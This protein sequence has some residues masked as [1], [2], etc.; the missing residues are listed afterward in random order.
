[1]SPPERAALLRVLAGAVMISFSA[2]LAKASGA[3][4]TTISFYRMAIGGLFL[5]GIALVRRERFRPWRAAHGWIL[6]AAVFIYLDL[7]A[8]HRS[9]LYVG[10]GLATILGNFQ[11]FFLALFGVFVFKEPLTPRLLGAMPLAMLGIWLLAGVDPASRGPHTLLGVAFGIGTALFYSAYLLLLRH[12]QRLH[13]RLPVAA[14]LALVSLASAGLALCTALTSGV[15]LAVTDTSTA[16]IFLAYGIFPQAIGWMLISSG[17][18][19]IPASLAG[20]LI[21]L[22][23]TL[24]FLWD[25]LLFNRPTGPIGYSGACLAVAAIYLGASGQPRSKPD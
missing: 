17:L 3:D 8:W 18:P 4:P 16:L 23:P 2:V 12:T 22:Q 14:N 25:I 5:L 15:S 19:K 11:V 10:P 9:I 7:E 13:D 24:T 6:A 1:M 21:L 20:L